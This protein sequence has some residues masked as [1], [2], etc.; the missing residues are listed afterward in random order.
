MNL[1]NGPI[2]GNFA[3]FQEDPANIHNGYTGDFA[4]IRNVHA[5]P[6]EQHI[7][8]LHN[9]QWVFNPNDDNSNYLDAQEI[10]PGSGHTYELANGGVGNRNKTAGDAIFHCHFYPHFAQGMWYHIRNHDVFS[11][12]TVLAVSGANDPQNPTTGFHANALRDLRSGKPAAG[13]RAHPDGELPD[14]VPIPAIVPLPGKPMPPMPGK[15]S[16]VAVDR[17]DFGLAAT[18]A[19]SPR[20]LWV[21]VPTRQQA[22]IESTCG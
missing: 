21:R 10:M 19:A 6:R 9:T 2:P 15:V 3:L 7:F 22:V 14:G 11:K 12:G 4:K 1:A 16:L 13:A 5:G 17:G 18:S 20:M 8:H